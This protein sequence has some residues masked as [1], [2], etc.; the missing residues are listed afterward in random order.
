MFAQLFGFDSWALDRDHC[1]GFS[2]GENWDDPRC[3]A[4]PDNPE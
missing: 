3:S 1:L 4:L 2:S